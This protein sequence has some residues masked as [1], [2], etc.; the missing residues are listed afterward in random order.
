MIDMTKKEKQIYPRSRKEML[1]IIKNAEKEGHLLETALEEFTMHPFSMPALWDCR[2]Y[3]WGIEQENYLK[4]PLIISLLALLS[5]MAGRLDEAKEYVNI[6]GE[7]P[8][9]WQP[10]DFNANDFCRVCTE[11]VMPYTEDFMFLRIVFFL[12]D[13]GAVPIL[14]LTLSACRPSII[15]GFR[16]FTRFGPC[17]ERYGDTIAQK[18]QKLYGSGGKGVYE[19]VLAEWHYQNNNC[20]RALVLVTGTIPLMEQEKDMR[21][22]FVGLALQMKILLVNG[23]TRT[24]K[25]LVEKIRDRIHKTGW[26]ELTS[27]L[28]ALE[29]LAACYDGRNEEVEEWLEKVAPDENKYIYMMDMYAYLIKLRC[30]IQTGKYMAAHVLVKQLITLLTQGKRHMDLCECYMLSAIIFYKADDKKHL[31]EELEKSLELAKKYKYIRLLADEGKCMVQML[32]IYQRERGA[33]DFTNQIMEL[34]AEVGMR[35]PNYLKSPAEYFEAL[36]PTEK[37]VLRLMAQ[38]M[39]NDEIANKTGKKTGTVKFHSNN[40]FRKLKVQN[41]QQAV[42]RGRDINLL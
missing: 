21:C 35:F 18:V 8:R 30:Y 10:Q 34:A 2:D 1:R 36:T 40:I 38:G 3:I 5:T 15:N 23:Q 31:C 22:L 6:L 19:I 37:T 11:L 33:D 32:S 39:S 16:D 13:V 9:H 28:N 12:I 24:A 42:N 41:R 25:P 29:C 20:F 26:E 17:L 14:S 7:T 27:S 4:K